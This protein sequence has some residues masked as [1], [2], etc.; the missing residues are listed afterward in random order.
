MPEAA[1]IAE[2]IRKSYVSGG[3]STL[4][5]RGID[6]S[7]RRGE[8]AFLVGPSGSGKSTLL[9]I[10]GCVLSPDE[11]RLVLLGEDVSHWTPR[12]RTRFRRERIGFVFQ[13]FHLFNGLTAL[14]NVRVPL[15]LLGRPT[16]EAAAEAA[17]LLESVGLAEKLKSR[18]TQLS[19]GQRQRVAVARALAGEPDLILAD[20]PTASLD[21][22]SGLNATQLLR[23]LSR[24]RGKTVIVVTHD[25]RIFSFADRI[26]HLEGGRIDQLT[27]ETDGSHAARPAEA[28]AAVGKRAP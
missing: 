22:E 28:H 26:F 9:S 19:I 10:L 27:S 21:A 5:L 13:R 16:R 4:V 23:D 6:L 8:C 17:Q 1:V 14:E 2:G 25:S 20:E 3:N 18:I 24:Q 11:G 12:E 7:I 15:D